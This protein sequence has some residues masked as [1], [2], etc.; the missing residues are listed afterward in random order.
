MFLS[1]HRTMGARS[2]FPV[3]PAGYQGKKETSE[4]ALPRDWVTSST[5][6]LSI[7]TERHDL[8]PVTLC[9]QRCDGGEAGW[10]QS[11]LADDLAAQDLARS[12]C[13]W[14]PS[15]GQRSSLS[16]VPF[17]AAVSRGSPP[18]SPRT[19]GTAKRSL[20]GWAWPTNLGQAG[21]FGT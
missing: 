15:R 13:S 11:S 3:L 14:P 12:C 10:K 2:A 20:C 5:A 21:F 1:I 6:V 19:Q 7:T 4:K 8:A 17:S 9:L 18:H 16:V